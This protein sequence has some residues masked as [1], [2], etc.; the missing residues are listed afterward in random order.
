MKLI[1]YYILNIPYLLY[2]REIALSS[3]KSV[4]FSACDKQIALSGVFSNDADCSCIRQV[5][6]DVLLRFAWILGQGG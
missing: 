4:P 3:K 6:G 2:H 1:V 5:A